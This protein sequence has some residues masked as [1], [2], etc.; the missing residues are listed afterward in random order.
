MWHIE[1]LHLLYV[2]MRYFF[3][4]RCFCRRWSIVVQTLV[5]LKYSNVSDIHWPNHKLQRILTSLSITGLLVISIPYLLFCISSKLSIDNVTA[6]KLLQIVK[7]KSSRTLRT[8]AMF[9]SYDDCN[10]LWD[11]LWLSCQAPVSKSPEMTRNDP[12]RPEMAFSIN[13]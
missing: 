6:I 12:Q 1:F 7:M 11:L 13:F 3:K 4:G 10:A 2:F 9:S 8:V 5:E